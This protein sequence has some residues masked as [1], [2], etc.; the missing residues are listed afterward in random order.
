MAGCVLSTPQPGRPPA[1]VGQ[2]LEP[3]R[4]GETRKG[5]LQGGAGRLLWGERC[6][7]VI[8]CDTDSTL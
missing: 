8:P 6:S 1:P 3:R 4:E 7:T 5:E 2:L